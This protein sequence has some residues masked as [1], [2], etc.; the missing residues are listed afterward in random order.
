MLERATR[1]CEA[2]LGAFWTYDGEYM[3]AAAMRGV[4]PAFAEF[5]QQGPHRLSSGQLSLLRGQQVLHTADIT[6]GEGYRSGTPMVR[7]AAVLG[8][9]RTLLVVP[10]RKDDAF[11]GTIGI[12]RQEVRPFSDKQIALLQNF[13]AQAVIAMAPDRDARGTGAADCD[14]RGIA[15]HQL[16]AR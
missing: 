2:E 16:L 4:T 11:L 9:V 5:L 1:L 12:Y 8:G 13:A 15:G 3:H 7:A 6:E 10:L 14:R